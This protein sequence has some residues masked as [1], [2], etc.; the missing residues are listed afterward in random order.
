MV[1]H[2]ITWKLKDSFSEEEKQQVKQG[3]KE[4]LEGL[5]GQI[6]GL[7]EIHVYTDGLA[8]ST[9]D[10]MLDSTFTDE[11][12]YKGYKTHPAHVAVADGKVRPNV[13][14]RLCMDFE[15]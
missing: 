3:I 13:E 12:A 7:L 1:R 2:I 15:V 10:L 5:L 11:A 9:A 14:T 8:S 4:G 6:P